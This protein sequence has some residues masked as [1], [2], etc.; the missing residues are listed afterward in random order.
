MMIDQ[1]IAFVVLYAWQ[2]LPENLLFWYQWALKKLTPAMFYSYLN[3]SGVFMCN[4]VLDLRLMICGTGFLRWK[5][6][7]LEPQI[8]SEVQTE[9]RRGTWGE[10][11][12]PRKT[13]RRVI[14]CT[15]RNLRCSLTQDSRLFLSRASLN[16]SV[17]KVWGV[18][19]GPRK[20]ADLWNP[21]FPIPDSVLSVV[22][23][24][25]CS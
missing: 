4:W 8:L 6:S 7:S 12:T 2:K 25:K 9:G 24:N 18:Q 17:A 21:G 23:T 15:W 16:V 20:T 22:L 10:F 19:M 11:Q 5:Q 1:Q 3:L 13:N 14:K